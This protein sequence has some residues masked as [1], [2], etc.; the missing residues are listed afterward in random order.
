MARFSKTKS[1]I[2]YKNIFLSLLI[3]VLI[4]FIFQG[5][6]TAFSKRSQEEQLD[7]LKQTLTQSVVHCYALEGT[8]PES[9]DYLKEHYDIV[10]DTDQF[11]VD[12]QPLGENI[13]PDITV[14][15]KKPTK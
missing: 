12:Y 5:A 8:Y 2:S 3:F 11:L 10:Y 14:I 1:T 13:M 7:N 6:V 4:I 9:L 15:S